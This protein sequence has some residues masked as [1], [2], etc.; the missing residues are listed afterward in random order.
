VRTYSFVT[1]QAG[2]RRGF[3]FWPPRMATSRS[4]IRLV[5]LVLFQKWFGS[6]ARISHWHK[7]GFMAEASDNRGNFVQVEQVNHYHRNRAG[8][9]QMRRPLCPMVVKKGGAR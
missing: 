8:S 2:S 9:T 6:R 7:D 5:A 4:R 3:D 1:G